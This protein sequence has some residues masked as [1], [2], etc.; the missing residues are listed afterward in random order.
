VILERYTSFRDVGNFSGHHFDTVDDGA[1]GE[2]ECTS[3]AI[4]VD[5]GQM[6]ERIEADCLVAGIVASH[7]TLATV[8]AHFLVNHSDNLL[9]VVQIA[10]GANTIDSRCDDL[11]DGQNG[12]RRLIGR[13]QTFRMV[14]LVQQVVFSF[15][16][17]YLLLPLFLERSEIRQMLIYNRG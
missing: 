8:D 15:G 11:A 3:G 6:G 17:G 14:T 2:T 9:F 7:V 1:D 12:S 13:S 4:V 16:N 5:F 10:I